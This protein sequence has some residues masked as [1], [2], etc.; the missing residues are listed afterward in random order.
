[1][2]R[3]VPT[4]WAQ[5]GVAQAINAGDLLM[6]LPWLAIAEI[7]PPARGELACALA[8]HATRTVRGQAAEL[9]MLP[10]GQLDWTSYLRAVEGKTGALIGLPVHGAALLSGRSAREAEL[11]SSAFVPLGVLF[12]LQD[13]VLDLYGDK[14]RREIGC[15]LYEGKV[16][17]LVVAHLRREPADA[18]WLL[19]LLRATREATDHTSVA[20]AIERFRESGAL[21]AVLAHIEQLA[22]RV[23]RS[24]LLIQTPALHAVAVNLAGVATAP[25]QHLRIAGGT[26]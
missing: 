25:I 12:Q 16:S 3:S 8:A 11:L 15:D 19:P 17:A 10:S 22:E 13:D 21:D 9:D 7:A 1:M 24:A 2:R 20:H 6:M 18:S 5:Y 23:A 26:K 4:L 14:G